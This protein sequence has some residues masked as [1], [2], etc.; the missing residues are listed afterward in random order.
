MQLRLNGW[1]R[2]GVVGTLLWLVIGLVLS[3]MLASHHT[4]GWWYE[5]MD[6]CYRINPEHTEGC[7]T[8][9]HKSML[10]TFEL[11]HSVLWIYA[12]FFTIGPITLG[13][14]CAYANVGKVNRIG[15]VLSSV[16][17]FVGSALGAELFF[18]GAFDSP[19]FWFHICVEGK[20]FSQKWYES[21]APKFFDDMIVYS[22]NFH[23]E[24]WM[25]ALILGI[26]PIALGWIV[27]AI[28]RWIR[29]GFLVQS[30]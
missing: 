29:K 19:K 8:G 24:Y 5:A 17:L 13:W 30:T 10:T 26:G 14:L 16:W 2:I 1:Q 18:R 3:G 6:L 15:L 27:L 28:V 4:S 20:G 22:K 25:Y 7:Y 23:D 11:Q 12:S 21:C 9:S